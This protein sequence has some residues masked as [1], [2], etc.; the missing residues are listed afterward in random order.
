MSVSTVK[1]PQWDKTQSRDLLNFQEYNYELKVLRLTQYKISQFG[2]V[3]QAWLAWYGK[4][5]LN[6]TKATIRQSKEMYY[7]RK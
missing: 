6:T 4:T 2:D 1:L 7:N 3:P 5:K